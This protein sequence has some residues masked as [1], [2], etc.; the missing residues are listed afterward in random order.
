MKFQFLLACLISL[1]T[2]TSVFAE[3]AN[4]D[5]SFYTGTFDVIDKEGD[6]QTTL[7]G[8]EHKNSD[9]FRDT[10]LGKF[11]PI[12]GGFITGKSSVYLYTWIEG[13]YGI[14]PLKILPSFTPG[15]YEKGDGKDL[16]SIFEFKSEIKIGFEIF[17]ESKLIKAMLVF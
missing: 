6:D 4:T 12:T 3:D 8:I 16:G 15:Y 1:F 11:K 13:Q 2:L 10:F 17:E 9:L 14:G 7:F 5:I